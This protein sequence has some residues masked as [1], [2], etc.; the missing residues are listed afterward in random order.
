MRMPPPFRVFAS[1]AVLAL[2]A[3]TG[4]GLI[5]KDFDGDVNIEFKV[6]STERTYNNV[7]T[8]DPDADQDVKENKDKIVAGSGTVQEISIEILSTG[9]ENRATLGSGT[10]YARVHQEG[11][12]GKTSP[13]PDDP[14]ERPVAVFE[15]VPLI[16]T[17]NFKLAI[18]PAQRAKLSTLVFGSNGIGKVDVKLRVESNDGPVHFEGRITFHVEFTAHL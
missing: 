4:C 1:A 13:W 15:A 8:V 12:D 2:F 3:A 11:A 17:Q 14:N 10:V 5:S 9:A 6:D 7:D 18:T 16:A